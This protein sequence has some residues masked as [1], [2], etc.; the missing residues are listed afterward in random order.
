MCLCLQYTGN[1][2]DNVVHKYSH[3]STITLQTHDYS[4]FILQDLI[5]LATAL[6]VMF[7]TLKLL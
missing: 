5:L 4:I 1:G 6:P 2:Y 7:G 3:P